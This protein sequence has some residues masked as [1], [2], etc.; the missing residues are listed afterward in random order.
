MRRV[1][2][3]CLLFVLFLSACGPAPE[4][5]ADQWQEQY[6]LGVR[7]LEE[8]NYEEA[9]IAFSAAIEV[10]P[11]RVEGY[12]GLADTYVALGDTEK[13]QDTLLQGIEKLPGN[14]IIQAQLDGLATLQ[15]DDSERNRRA[16]EQAIQDGSIQGELVECDLT[17]FGNRNVPEYEDAYQASGADGIMPFGVRFSEAIATGLGNADTLNEAE[18]DYGNQYSVFQYD[19]VEETFENW[20]DVYG[21][22]IDIPLHVVGFLTYDQ[23]FPEIFYS[24]NGLTYYCPNGPYRFCVISFERK[25]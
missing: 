4:K 8:G 7:F 19:Q 1:F 23:D 25:M 16:V 21:P 15:V 9:I 20:E 14:A 5:T 6:D 17:I 2:G 3:W 10:D 24:S 12:I 11:K 18:L 13:A 22:C